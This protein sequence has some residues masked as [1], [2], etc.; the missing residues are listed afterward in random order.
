MSADLNA[1]ALSDLESRLPTGKVVHFYNLFPGC[2]PPQRAARDGHGTIPI[3]AYRHCEALCSAAAFG[4]H[5]FPP[6]DFQLVWDGSTEIQWTYGDA[7][8]WYPLDVAQFPYFANQ[9]DEG[10]PDDARGFSPP[11]LTAFVEPGV[12]QIWTGLVARTAPGWNL[13]LRPPANVP[14]DLGYEHFEGIVETDRWFGP[15]FFNVRL[16][17]TEVPVRFRAGYPVMQVQPV[18]RE[19]LGLVDSFEVSDGLASLSETDW[20]AFRHTVVRPNQDP[21]RI[22]GA[23]GAESRRGKR[24]GQ[25]GA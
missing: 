18:R 17:R 16:T 4:W 20:E 25:E 8:G 15:L 14:R 3:R 19:M 13:L 5:V 6:M 21:S 2:R 7:E 10:A 23:Y 24:R 9:F 1:T 12:V 11:F 22:R